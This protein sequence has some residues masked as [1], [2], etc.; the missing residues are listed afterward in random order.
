MRVVHVTAPAKFGG[1]ETVV[2][3]LVGAQRRRGLDVTV[4]ASI[5]EGDFEGH[6]FLEQVQAHGVDVVPLAS[7]PGQLLD[8]MRAL[9]R[10]LRVLKPDVVHSHGY[11][12][13]IMTV[14]LRPLLRRPIISTAHG[15]TDVT[16]RVTLYER[17]NRFAMRFFDTVAAVSAPLQRRLET[18]GIQ[19]SRIALVPN[20]CPRQSFFPRAEARRTL[21]IPDDAIAI[22]WVGRCSPEKNVALFIEAIALMSPTG[23]LEVSVIG[24]GPDVE[25]ARANAERL[26][27]SPRV[28]WHGRLPNAGALLAAFDAVALTSTTEGTPMVLLEAMSAGVAIAAT[29]VGGVPELLG[30]G[31]AGLLV[32]SGDASALAAALSRLAQNPEEREAIVVRA[33]ARVASNYTLGAWAARYEEL[34]LAIR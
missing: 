13:D 31:T 1:L 22:G 21:G 23:S 19:A 15:F 3:A 29:A 4:V 11:R 6:P 5:N 26:G 25:P 20:G 9:R 7:R 17:A 12:A 28:R 8:E 2:S 24:D 34:Y 32:P 14:L 10:A 27:I 30:E 16:P 33:L 18:S